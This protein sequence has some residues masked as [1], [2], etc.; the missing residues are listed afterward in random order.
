MEWQEMSGTSAKSAEARRSMVRL[1]LTVFAREFARYSLQ[2]LRS[3][4]VA[5]LLATSCV[6]VATSHSVRHRMTLGS[7][8]EATCHV[9]WTAPPALHL[10]LDNQGPGRLSFVALDKSGAR[11]DQGEFGVGSRNLSWKRADGEVRLVLRADARGAQT[12][13]YFATSEGLKVAID[14]TNATD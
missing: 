1:I 14:K 13:C 5:A 11:L 9:T 3:A 10:R 8:G 6:L 12:E 7:N 4:A 2:M